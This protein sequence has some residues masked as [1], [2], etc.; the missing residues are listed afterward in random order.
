V[1][2]ER[3][4]AISDASEHPALS[5]E[6]SALRAQVRE[7]FGNVVLSMMA[8]PRYQY[9]S[10]L[11]LHHLVLDPLIRDRVAIAY[12]SEESSPN[13]DIARLALWARVS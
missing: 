3:N 4:G 12:R 9:Q 13:A 11:D 2:E 1:N 10:L 6:L 5:K 8:L 7:N